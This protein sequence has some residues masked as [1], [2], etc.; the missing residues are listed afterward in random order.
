MKPLPLLA[1]VIAALS[2]LCVPVRVSAQTPSSEIKAR[3]DALAGLRIGR[4]R[5]GLPT[6]GAL[7]TSA[8]IGTGPGG[9]DGLCIVNGAIAPINSA[10][11][12]I[13]FQANLPQNWNA[14]AVQMGGGGYDGFMAITR[15]HPFLPSD[16]DP[17]RQGYVS[18]GSDSGHVG[19]HGD[20]MAAVADASFAVDAEARENFAY[21]QIKKTHDV[22][23]EIISAYYGKRPQ[24]VYF[25]GNS[26]GG[27]EG[28]LAAQ[29]F[30][31]DYD[32]VV[33]IH[34]AYNF[35]ALQ[36]G[37]LAVAQSLYR[38]PKAW[39]SSG[40]LKTIASAVTAACDGLDGLKDGVI[41]NLG[42]CRALFR[43]DR[44]A[45]S[46]GAVARP[47]CLTADQ[48]R[49]V[50]DIAAPAPLGM[51]VSGAE[52]FG[53]WPILEGAFSAPTPFGMGTS[54]RPESP[55][56]RNDSFLFVMAD[57]GVR[58]LLAQD[59]DASSL[60]FKASEHRALIDRASTLIDVDT[61]NFDRFRQRGGK[62]LLM[63][64]SIDMAI[65]PANTIGL[66]GRM[67]DRYG[68]DMDRFAKFYMAYGFG[69]GD[70]A[71]QIEWNSLDALDRWVETGR[72]PGPQTVRDRSPDH[73]GRTMPLCE[74]PAWPR[75]NGRGDI[76]QAS[77]FTCV[78]S[79][80]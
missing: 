19:G 68:A 60:S 48:L 62:M 64:G 5:I 32:G 78:R 61:A 4:D 14:K 21:A 28:L 2:M 59:P 22:A 18:F 27:H 72:A 56:S 39:L 13:N 9:P 16:R 67:R 20:Q 43:I 65:P 75:Y 12:P 69:H 42:Q 47:D 55:P 34:P 7:I 45:C 38:D 41:A 11:P 70:G 80:S 1:G 58:F 17:V 10:S 15:D 26:Q 49:T 33:A 37:G 8:S 40:N 66:V 29:R 23:I 30:G 74:Y 36:L 53:G 79:K 52:T 71:F 76:R 31:D 3:C 73:A 57:Q 77:S 46:K 35:V 50:Q 54:P 24:R 63:H 25:Y 6:T 44:L 51:M